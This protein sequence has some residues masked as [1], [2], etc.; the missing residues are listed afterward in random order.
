MRQ[1]KHISN[2]TVLC[3]NIWTLILLKLESKDIV[4]M[5]LTISQEFKRFLA[6]KID[7][8]YTFIKPRY[9]DFHRASLIWYTNGYI[10]INCPEYARLVN[11]SPFTQFWALVR[12]DHE[13]EFGMPAFGT[14]DS[15]EQLAV[16]FPK[17]KGRVYFSKYV[18]EDVKRSKLRTNI[19]PSKWGDYCGDHEDDIDRIEYLNEANGKEGRPLI[20]VI[21]TFDRRPR[22]FIESYK[23]KDGIAIIIE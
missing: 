13:Q 9:A 14:C 21:Y 8:T 19:R 11:Q 5:V 12:E 22:Q 16:R 1:T 23:F 10:R 4:K 3:K 7:W 20:N 18:R 17:Y 6:L 2:P 15:P